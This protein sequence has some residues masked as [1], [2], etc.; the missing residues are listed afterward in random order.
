MRRKRARRDF[1]RR[2]APIST[3]WDGSIAEMQ[4]ISANFFATSFHRRSSAFIGG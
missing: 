4:S 1:I 3:D 2:L